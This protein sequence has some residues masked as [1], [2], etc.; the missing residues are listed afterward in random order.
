MKTLASF[1][2]IGSAAAVSIPDAFEAWGAVHRPGYRSAVDYSARLAV[3]AENQHRIAAHNAGNHTWLMGNNQFSDMT[4]AEFRAYVS[5]PMPYRGDRTVSGPVGL[6]AAAGIDWSASGA[7]TEVK[8]QGQCGSCWA[9]AAVG[10]VEG[11]YQIKTGTLVS[12]SAQQLVSCDKG[13]GG[14]NGGYMDHAFEWIKHHAGICTAKDYPYSATDHACKTQCTALPDTRVRSYTDLPCTPAAMKAALSQ[15][16]VSIAVHADTAFQL[17]KSGV[18]TAACGS[19]I[20]HG[21]LAVGYG[22]DDGVPYY[23]VKNSW[24]AHWGEQGYIRLV[25]VADHTGQCGMYTA[26]SYPSL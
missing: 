13:D 14:C 15:Q 11:A 1:L 20:D 22:V 4:G 6:T 26:A 18:L 19:Q 7:V 10:A 12:L 8:D 17:Y 16:P 5:R 9:F 25:D 3:F 2:V 24:G 23:K 21:V